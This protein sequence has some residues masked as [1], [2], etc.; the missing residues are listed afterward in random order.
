VKRSPHVKKVACAPGYSPAV[1]ARF[2]VTRPKYT[3]AVKAFAA[4]APDVRQ[5]GV[6][7]NHLEQ[8]CVEATTM[9]YKRKK[10]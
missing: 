8:A 6:L 9:F 4:F 10:R 3:E 5:F 1:R 7:I 2:D